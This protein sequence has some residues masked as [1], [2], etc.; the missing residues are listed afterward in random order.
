MPTTS[1]TT[2]IDADLK[3]RLEEVARR[4]GRS[5]SYVA[6]LAIRNLVEE[7]EATR[8]LLQAGL[9][10]AEA[11]L[12]VAEA[13]VEAWLNDPDDRPFPEAQGTAS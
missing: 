3:A 5:A 11:G 13:E 10:L 2:R 12:S 7:R 8:E 6:N 1:F 4:D 9:A